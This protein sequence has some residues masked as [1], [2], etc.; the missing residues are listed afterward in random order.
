MI[1]YIPDDGF[2]YLTLARHFAESGMWTFDGVNVTSGF[3]LLWG[4]LLSGAYFIFHPSVEAFP[5]IGLVIS[6]LIL[7]GTLIYMG[8]GGN[9]TTIFWLG[10]LGTSS[11]FILN[12]I[13]LTEFCLVIICAYCVIENKSPFIFSLLGVLTRTEFIII[14]MVVVLIGIFNGEVNYK[15]LGGVLG[16]IIV[17]LHSYLFTGEFIQSSALIKSEWAQY[18]SK[19]L[20]HEKAL[21]L[22]T[23]FFYAS[24]FMAKKIVFVSLILTSGFLLYKKFR[25]D[26]LIAVLLILIYTALYWNNAGVQTW[27]MG[28]FVIPIFIIGKYLFNTINVNLARIVL[29]MGIFFNLIS[30]YQPLYP[31]G[32]IM[33]RAGEYLAQNKLDGKIGSWNAGIIGYYQGGSV[34]NLDGLVNN[35]ICSYIESGTVVEYLK[36]NKV[37]YIIDFS[38][39]YRSYYPKQGGYVDLKVR[40][41]LQF[42]KGEYVW[43]YLT[44]AEVI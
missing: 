33:K 41:L 26:L 21:S 11:G 28:V 17:L 3:H 30:W 24:T 27:Y 18:Y 14:P 39:M 6:G 9:L 37:K 44:I 38:N 36:E 34:V 40:L 5:I 16:M 42:D 1:Q 4:Y 29:L 35:S 19:D 43:K 8:W 12:A 7:L 13:S 10:F 31:H 22:S 25:K 32:E 15:L 2:Y 23:G 20:L